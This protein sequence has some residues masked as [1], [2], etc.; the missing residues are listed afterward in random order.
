MYQLIYDE[1]KNEIIQIDP[2]GKSTTIA[3]DYPSEPV[4]SPNEQKAIYISPLEWECPGSLYLYNLENGYIEEIISP[5][6]EV[7][8]DIPKYAIWLDDN[9]IGVI[10]GFSMGTVAVGGNVFIYNIENKSLQQVTNYPSEIQ[11]TQIIKH[12][13]YL[14][15]QGIQYTDSILNNF[16]EFHEKLSLSKIA[17]LE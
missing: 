11:V 14:E 10:I 8:S 5:T 6:A 9:N 12:E 2:N 4:F 7:M 16:K 3:N 15:L 13:D 17:P 1:L